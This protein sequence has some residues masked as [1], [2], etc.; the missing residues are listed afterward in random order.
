[1][2]SYGRSFEIGQSGALAIDGVS[3]VDLVNQFKTP[4]FVISEKTLRENYRKFYNAFKKHY[5]A[6]FLVAV[7]MKANWG[8]A[9]RKVIASEGGGGEAF[10]LGELYVALACGTPPENIVINGTNKTKDI[11]CAAIDAGVIINVDSLLELEKIKEVA[12]YNNNVAKIMLRIRL[13]LKYVAGKRHIDPRH[14]APGV[15]ISKFESECKFG[16]EPESLF[17]AV[18]KA[19]VTPEIALKG[20]MYHGGVVR[21]AGFYKEVASELMDYV[22]RVKESF[23]WVPEML[24][25]GGGFVPVRFGVDANPPTPEDY[26]EGLSSIIAE[27]SKTIGMPVPKLI[28]EPGRYCIE[29]AITWLTTVGDIKIDDTV[30]RKTWVYVDG[31]INEMGDPFDSYVSYHH[32][33][34]SNE[35]TRPGNRV[36]DICGQLCNGAD[37]LAKN[38][39]MPEIKIGDILAFM[40]MGAYNESFANQSNA[41]PR[42]ATVMVSEGRSSVVRRPETYQNVLSREVV[43]FWLFRKE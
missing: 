31:N 41:M 26:A 35:P 22:G 20:L 36:V 13:P 42:S 10:G 8:F 32:V 15:D 27:R 38:R 29:S 30:A 6:D 3:I 24:D 25:L 11:L 23:N 14:P 34:V 37:I 7:G 33:I 39:S 28:V 1:M 16:M 21:R 9:V 19:L 4:L 18:E 12:K 43:P 40:D 5:P 17:T 2:Q